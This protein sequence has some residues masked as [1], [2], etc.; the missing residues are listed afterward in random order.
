[1]KWLSYFPLSLLMLCC[2]Q[3][4]SVHKA[5]IDDAPEVFFKEANRTG[6]FTMLNNATG[7]VTVYNMAEDT[8]RKSPGS[9]LDVLLSLIALEN[10]IIPDTK[11][12]QATDSLST[13]FPSTIREAL[14][15]HNQVYYSKL[16][17]RLGVPTVQKWIDSI[18]YGNQAIGNEL[19]TTATDGRLRISPDEQLGL[20]KRLYFN[21]LPF[22]KSV[23]DTV[24]QL[25]RREDNTLYRLSYA[26]SPSASM[27]G[28]SAE[29]IVGWIEENEHVYFFATYAQSK[30][31][32]TN[33]ESA[34]N[35]TRKILRSY[36]FFE[37]K[38]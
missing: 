32:V 9:T 27:S 11:S 5:T 24:K 31:V 8:I 13:P 38:K 15:T 25:M 10:G 28:L 16:L 18:H 2:W 1:M 36:G 17:D 22:R 20:M 19:T 23:Q 12:I 30:S 7:E 14:A 6:C 3:G 33:A 4:C 37:G 35:I 29:W 26:Y 34:L 21:Q